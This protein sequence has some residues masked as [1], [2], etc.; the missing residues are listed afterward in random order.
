MSKIKKLCGSIKSTIFAVIAVIALCA[1]AFSQQTWYVRKDG[2]DR[3]HC[4]GLANTASPGGN[5]IQHCALNDYRLLYDDQHGT[6]KWI[7]A[8]GDTVILQKAEWRV[9]WDQGV[10]QSD[11][12]GSAGLGPQAS[13]APAIPAGSPTTH[14]RF[15]GENYASCSDINKTQLFGG[16]G[17]YHVL[18]LAATLY[19]DVQCIELTRHSQCIQHGDPAAPSTCSRDFPFDDYA[20]DGVVTDQGTHDV[21][22]QDVWIH[23][24]PDR[25]VLGPIGGVVT[26]LRCDIAYNGMAGWD[27]DD[28][29]GRD[30][31]DHPFGS[32]SINNAT[33]NFVSSTIE[34]S[35]CN[36]AY[37]G[38]GAISCY[39]QSNGAYGD[40]MG[41]PPGT[42]L[43]VNF[44]HSVSRYNVQD[45][46]DPGHI[47]TGASTI[48]ITNST[49]YGNGGEQ[50][51]W[52][53]NFTSAT[54][55]GNTVVA[56][57][58][59]MASPLDGNAPA[60]NANLGDFCRAGVTN[61]T[62]VGYAP[63]LFTLGCSTVGGCPNGHTTFQSNIVLGYDNPDAYNYGAKNGGPSL[64]YC[65]DNTTTGGPQQVDC[66][67]MGVF[68]RSNNV[69]FGTRDGNCLSTET[70]SD[71]HFVNEP[72]GNG[73]SFTPAE[74]DVFNT[75]LQAGSSATG[76][77]AAAQ[78]VGTASTTVTTPPVVTP[79]VVTPPVVAPPATDPSAPTATWFTVIPAEQQAKTLSVSVPARTTYRFIS[80]NGLATTPVTSAGG[81]VSDWDDGLNGDPADPDPNA[82][83]SMQILELTVPQIVYVFDSSGVGATSTMVTVPAVVIV[84]V[85][86]VIT[87]PTPPSLS[88]TDPLSSTQLNATASTSGV[89]IYTPAFGTFLPLGNATLSLT[90]V[91]T[92]TVNFKSTSRTVSLVV[93]S[94]P[95]PVAAS[96]TC[97][98]TLVSGKI[99]MSCA[100]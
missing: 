70:C 52:G 4:D 68:A 19:V 85:E 79:P 69:I 57:C 62:L 28:G 10:S 20:V 30:G 15:L 7:I 77:G 11:A 51:K 45:G 98:A 2:G 55:T 90:F 44:D 26:C 14:T 89:F 36:Q 18:S 34:Y 87:W 9:G 29:T 12:W 94:P 35:G 74:L 25:G 50:F 72:R 8:G 93:T 91:P 95:A 16:F 33:W 71:P 17:L 65:Q 49:F 24:F 47:D 40:G 39:G 22:M 92:D 31:T 83:K 76:L 23:G 78:I 48:S 58:L 6:L 13:E 82:A 43:N 3:L 86:P 97:T 88:V 27:F 37:P 100:Q 56:N 54:V 75:A 60:Y 84:P 21:L 80:V 61:N 64:F 67:K 53:Y 46:I 73:T 81:T 41:A 96:V 59:R 32:P 1:P 99:V 5:S 63:T 42:A 38:T 66:S